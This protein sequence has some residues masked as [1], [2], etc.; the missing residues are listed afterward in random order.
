MGDNSHGPQLTITIC[1]PLVTAL[2]RQRLLPQFH[3]VKGHLSSSCDLALL[4]AT[5]NLILSWYFS[6]RLWSMICHHR[7]L[8]V[9]NHLPMEKSWLRQCKHRAFCCLV[10]YWTTRHW[11]CLTLVLAKL[12]LVRKIKHTL[13]RKKLLREKLE[14][15]E[16][17][18]VDRNVKHYDFI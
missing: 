3:Q 8:V 7:K 6:S 4:Y 10:L 12:W 9:Y 17:Y 2:D 16:I 14:C 1:N 13:T 15:E 18:F 5:N 11:E